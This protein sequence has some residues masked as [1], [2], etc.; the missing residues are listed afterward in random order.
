MNQ[1]LSALERLNAAKAANQPMRIIVP[2]EI[3]VYQAAI[4]VHAKVTA[5]AL[6]AL[7]HR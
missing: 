3:E 1:L 2:A 5:I 7:A 4:R 6:R